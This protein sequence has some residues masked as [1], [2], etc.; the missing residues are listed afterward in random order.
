MNVFENAKFLVGADSS[1]GVKDSL[2]RFFSLTTDLKESLRDKK[3]LINEYLLAVFNSL[4]Y[5]DN[6][7]ATT[8]ADNVYS[9]VLDSCRVIINGEK[10]TK[11]NLFIKTLRT[12]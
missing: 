4:N 5:V 6:L 3:E 2:N 12:I 7:F 8:K 9:N 11:M 1:K 10:S